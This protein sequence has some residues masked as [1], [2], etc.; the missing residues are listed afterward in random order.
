V[1]TPITIGCATAGAAKATAASV[2]AIQDMNFI[3]VSLSAPHAG[4]RTDYR[5]VVSILE[6]SQEA[7]L[8]VN[9]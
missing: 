8:G 3:A 1:D 2:P 9:A 4:I 5:Y 6:R 7:C